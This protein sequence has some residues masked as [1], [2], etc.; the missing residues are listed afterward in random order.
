MR[1][2]G[3]SM[4]VQGAPNAGRRAQATEELVIEEALHPV[5]IGSGGATINR[6]RTETGA[7]IDLQ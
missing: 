3:E 4:A 5:I 7:R 6:I 1:R 2:A